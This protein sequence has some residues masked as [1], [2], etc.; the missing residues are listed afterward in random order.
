[1]AAG[2]FSAPTRKLGCVLVRNTLANLIGH[3]VLSL[4]TLLFGALCDSS[5]RHCPASAQPLVSRPGWSDIWWERFLFKP[6][7]KSFWAGVDTV[8]ALA[9]NHSFP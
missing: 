4:L 9:S 2:A 1:M 3:A 5:A 7:I 6:S 8:H